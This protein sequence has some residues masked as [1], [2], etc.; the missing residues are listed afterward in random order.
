MKI[1]GRKVS[2]Y[3]VHSCIVPV[4]THKMLCLLLVEKYIVGCVPKSRQHTV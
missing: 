4:C 2:Y 1:R 3:S